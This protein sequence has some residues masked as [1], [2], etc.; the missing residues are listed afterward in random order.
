VLKYAGDAVIGYFP[1]GWK[2]SKRDLYEHTLK[3]TFYMQKLL[4]ES[5]NKVL[6]INSYPKLKSRISIDVG[7]NQIVILGSEPDLLGHVI[8]R[9]AKIMSKASPNN[10]VLGDNIFKNL[11]NMSKEKFPIEDKFTLF[12]TGEI[13]SIHISNKGKG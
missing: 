7:E 12:E 13:Y 2:L 1:I 8:S 10:I 6:F 11:C 4:D 9:A 5:I 3:C